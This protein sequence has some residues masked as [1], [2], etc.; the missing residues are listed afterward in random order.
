MIRVT[1][2][3]NVLISGVDAN[4]HPEKQQAY[5]KLLVLQGLGLID[6]GMTTRFEQDKADDRDAARVKQHQQE[7]SKFASPSIPGPARWDH[8]RWGQDVWGGDTM[9]MELE[10]LFGIKDF[11]SANKHTVWD[12]DHHYGHRVAGRDYFLTYERRLLNRAKQL[13]S[14][15]VRVWDTR[16]F[17]NAVQV[18]EQQ[19]EIL[20]ELDALLP[21]V[22]DRAFKGEL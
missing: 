4:E 20:D 8:S 15:G 19:V 9:S 12:I 6:I 11:A 22:L 17:V 5:Q 3:M 18:A 21:T 2:D 10:Q 13:N 16:K 1:L 14:I 7:L